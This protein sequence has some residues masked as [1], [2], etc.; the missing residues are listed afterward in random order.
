MKPIVFQFKEGNEYLSSH[1]GLGLIGA[2][3]NRTKLKERLCEI[4]VPGCREPKISH[5]M[6]V[7][8]ISKSAVKQM[9]IGSS[10]LSTTI[11]E[12]VNSFI[13]N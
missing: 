13:P 7:L 8:I 1:S 4:E 2:L 5:S 10:K 12:S 9:L 6:T 3:L 11:T